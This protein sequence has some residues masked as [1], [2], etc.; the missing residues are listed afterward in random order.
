MKAFVLLV[1]L[2]V[3]LTASCMNTVIPSPSTPGYACG[4]MGILCDPAPGESPKCCDRDQTCGI[5]KT[6]SAGVCRWNGGAMAS[7]GGGGA[8]SGG[9]VMTPQWSPRAP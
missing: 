1:V 9:P 8:E 6:A 7:R 2:V 5:P 3:A 4:V